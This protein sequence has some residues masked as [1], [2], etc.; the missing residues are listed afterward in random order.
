MAAFVRK[1]NA[2][3]FPN[4]DTKQ[5]QNLVIWLE[6]KKIRHYKIEGRK[7]LRQT[8]DITRWSQTF[9]KYLK[10]LLCPY[11]AQEDRAVLIDWLLGLAVRLT[12]GESPN[13]YRKCTATHQPTTNGAAPSDNPLDSFNFDDPAVK[14]GITSVAAL[15]RIP[16]HHDHIE[17]FKA[18]CTLVKEK[19]S[20]EALQASQ[21]QNSTSQD[22]LSLDTLSMGFATGDY[23]TD[24]AVKILRLLHIRNLRELQSKINQA[25]VSVQKVTAEPKT[26]Q[27]LGKI[28]R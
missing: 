6:D 20:R 23:I 8:D 3:G 28:G 26:D 14:A 11:S 25:L 18:I 7:E 4:A 5:F 12:Y 16:P 21:Q 10:D 19:L 1:F 15:L 24:E 9:Q 13:K 2:L 27:R 17:V 22:K